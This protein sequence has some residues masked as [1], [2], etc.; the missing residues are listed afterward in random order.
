M[1]NYRQDQELIECQQMIHELSLQV[2]DLLEAMLFFAGVKRSKLNIAV[3]K[4]IEALDI[5]FED[6]DSEMTL[7]EIIKVIEYLKKSNKELF[8]NSSIFH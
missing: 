3:Q 8:K 6:D 4:Y 7:D 1:A 5:V 2:N